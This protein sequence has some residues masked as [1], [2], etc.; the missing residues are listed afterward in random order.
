MAKILVVDDH[1][2]NREFLVTLLGYPG[3]SL[4]EASD[5][6][7]ALEVA[8]AVRPDLI[9]T[10]VLMPTMD[11][12]EFV[13]RLRAIPEIA[14]TPVIFSTAH[15]RE[16]DAKVL[17]HE[18]GVEHIL[19]KP[20]EP[21]IV[22][23]TVDACLGKASMV[24]PVDVPESFDREHMRLLTDRLSKVN[25]RLEALV[26]I[27]LHLSSDSLSGGLFEEFCK[28]A[29]D[30]N[31]ARRAIVVIESKDGVELEQI[32][33][34]GFEF[35][36]DSILESTRA[37]SSVFSAV[38]KDRQT[39]RLHNPGGDPRVL[40]FPVGFP[41]FQSFLA[42]RITS[43][44]GGLGWLLL[45][46]RLGMQEFNEEDERLA[47]ILG[48]LVGRILQ[49][50]RLYDIAQHQAAELAREIAQRQQAE[51]A[52]R[53]SELRY[54]TYFVK[55]PLPGW[56]F[57]KETLRFL[58][59]N[60]AVIQDYGFTREEFL[61]MTVK[62]IRSPE[63]IR[64]MLHDME[65]LE[66]GPVS[67]QRRHRKKDG[68][69]INVELMWQPLFG[70]QQTIFALARDVT[71]RVRHEAAL[72]E[73]SERLDLALK[74]SRTGVWSTYPD[75]RIVWDAY[76][77][78]I[79]GIPQGSFRGTPAEL[80]TI[81]HPEDRALMAEV[82]RRMRR[83]DLD[84]H[85]EYRVIWADGTVHNLVTRGQ[86]VY[87]EFGN[88]SRVT[89]VCQDVTEQRL[90]E[91]QYR[92]AQ[93]MEAVGQLAAGIAHDFN[94]VLT[95]ILGYCSLLL[96]KPKSRDPIRPRLLEIQN[97]GERA[98][99]LTQQL[100]AYSRKQVLQPRVLNLASTLEDLDR[101]LTRVLGENIEIVT[102]ID[103]DLAQ[104]RIDPTQFQQVMLNL[105]INARDAMPAGGKLTLELKNQ[106][107]NGGLASKRHN[108]P[109]G[110]YVM[111]A[112]SDNGIG[113][114]PEVRD[115]VFEPFF[116]TKE[117][118]RGTGLGL[119][120]VYGIVRQSGGHIWLYSEP[121][122]GTTFRIFLP[123]VDET[124]EVLPQPG[125]SR[126]AGGSETILLVEDESGVRAL[127]TEILESVGYTIL[128]CDTGEEAFLAAERHPGNIDLL[129]SDVVLQTIGGRQIA[130]QITGQRPTVKVLFI[131][132][133]TGDAIVHN[134]ILDPN[135]DFLQKPFTAEA[136]CTKV[137]SILDS[138]RKIQHVLVVDDDPS[139]R[140]LLVEILQE[141][142]FRVATAVNGR[143]AFRAA[144]DYPFDLVITDLVMPDHEGIELIRSLKKGYPHLRII[145]ISG[146]VGS[147]IFDAARIL[148]ADATLM[149]PLSA[150]ALLQC[151]NN[152]PPSPPLP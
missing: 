19:P 125:I 134:G 152:L 79:H 68:S 137:R 73:T 24:A 57:D 149:K 77:H 85:A 84:V 71:E 39:L 119:A 59:V 127:V 66:A 120:T 94:N 106:E 129:I 22:L 98:A 124:P 51:D 13:R 112:V 20:C 8:A 76:T 103:K 25:S 133:Y 12:Y 17:A 99:T 101:L 4:H 96:L 2:V 44:V 115:K 104:V 31:S 63:D 6:A 114:K 146:A 150:D 89:G 78:Q 135:A 67:A 55:N 108:V 60:E 49:K 109:P 56:V 111:L 21:E 147:E 54:R 29:R 75:G 138:Q 90:L 70:A 95:V 83:G 41:S 92:Q 46:D 27:S 32:S 45:F 16:D 26:Q 87:D 38:I 117:P 128:A 42:A 3:H 40:G 30:L 102:H 18:C 28:S 23:K 136:L 58:D 100:L 93:K 143:E 144:S 148:G 10:D 97:A 131:S 72:K 14:T 118:G 11:G 15:Y 36:A 53:N 64:E 33:T 37:A 139:I 62:D 43:T 141:S 105:A 5:G 121:G 116:T 145:A 80:F 52:L 61:S 110:R 48:A 74:V 151:I 65:E 88:L 140:S 1:R 50:R 86:A 82:T 35:G 130:E 132:G 123:R 69:I 142:G 126:M 91:E 47:G 113:M 81:F 34:S 7:E 107:T 122:V 9:I